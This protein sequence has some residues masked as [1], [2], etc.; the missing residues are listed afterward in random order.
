MLLY[1]YGDE[2]MLTRQI[3]KALFESFIDDIR[4]WSDLY[5]QEAINNL[6]AIIKVLGVGN[7]KND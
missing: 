3:Q 4:S 2:E 7:K 6:Q 1:E 5:K